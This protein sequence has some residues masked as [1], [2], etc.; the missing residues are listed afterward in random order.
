MSN[1]SN[2][3]VLRRLAG[4]KLLSC[5]GMVVA[6]FLGGGVAHGEIIWSGDYSTGDFRQ[7]H[8]R[9]SSNSV[10][11]WGVPSYGRP[12]DPSEVYHSAHRGNGE[13]ISIVSREADPANGIEKG[14]VRTGKY[15]ARFTAKNSANGSEPAD[16]GEGGNC[17]IR[18]TELWAHNMHSDYYNAMPYLSERWMSISVYLPEDFD[19]RNY[20]GRNGPIVF[21]VKSRNQDGT[22][23]GP[24]FS[25]KAGGDNL[26]EGW[27]LDHRW[28]PD[29]MPVEIPWQYLDKW[30]GDNEGNA[31][32]V[33]EDFPDRA[34]SEAALRS[35]NRG[36]WTDWIIHVKWDARGKRRGGEGFLSVW[37]REDDGEWIHV[38]DARPREITR[39]GMTFDRGIGYRDD[40]NGRNS[41][42]FGINAGL[43]IARANVVLNSPVNKTI[44]NDNIK[45]GS[46]RANFAMMSP[47]GSEPGSS[48]REDARPNPPTISFS[49]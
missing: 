12:V 49:N 23:N 8:T 30:E 17:R 28:S 6:G 45:I 37:K 47:D 14:P 18:R 5:Y 9:E 33:L 31:H 25:I 40:R 16:C 7:W 43:Y 32:A 29:Q 13:L 3:S 4:A 24:T 2:I 44:Y 46:D 42:G 27:M 19:S 11:F 1:T 48:S 39:G 34:V 21:Q 36:G 10:S 35:L 38:L 41:G 15:A 20:G 26:E 22:G